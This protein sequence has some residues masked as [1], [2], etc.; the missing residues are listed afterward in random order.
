MCVCVSHTHRSGHPGSEEDHRLSTIFM[1][2]GWKETGLDL[3]GLDFGWPTDALTE[4]SSVLMTIPR[5]HPDVGE[6]VWVGWA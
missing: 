5:K 2:I 3:T 1:L 4:Q 6:S